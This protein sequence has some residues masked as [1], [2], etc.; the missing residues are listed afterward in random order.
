[1]NSAVPKSRCR[2]SSRELFSSAEGLGELV[3]LVYDKDQQ[4]AR[5]QDE[6]AE[7]YGRLGFL[8][9]RVQDLEQQV[10][11]LSGPS[12]KDLIDSGDPEPTNNRRESSDPASTSTANHPASEQNGPNSAP[13]ER[14]PRPWWRR[15][16]G[17]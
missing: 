13:C 8:Q 5:L 12:I 3:A 14:E 17:W 4:I 6:R 10:K 15:W 2:T 7:L 11:L 9:A 16:L 1:M